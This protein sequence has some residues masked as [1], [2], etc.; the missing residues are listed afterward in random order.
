MSN[1]P[2]TT[3]TESEITQA[4]AAAGALAAAH[5]AAAGG[6]REAMHG[7]MESA[8]QR[9]VTRVQGRILHGQTLQVTLAVELLKR[10]F[11]NP[12][13]AASQALESDGGHDGLLALARIAFAFVEPREAYDM[14]RDVLDE[15]E[16]VDQQLS[17]RAYDACAL[18]IVGGWTPQDIATFAQHLSGLG[19]PAG[20]TPAA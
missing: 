15:T 14:L 7:L 2:N 12:F 3:L 16:A 10:T 8:A 1:P 13:D 5:A 6:S 4:Q 9:P 20:A 18:E 17:R 11:D 19:K